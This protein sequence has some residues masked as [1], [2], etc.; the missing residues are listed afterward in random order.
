MY[1]VCVSCNSPLIP[2]WAELDSKGLSLQKNFSQ[3]Q[4]SLRP[5]QEFVKHTISGLAVSVCVL[6]AWGSPSSLHALAGLP[7][8]PFL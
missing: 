4:A 1:S 2:P 6:A 5:F 8:T 3:E 7:E